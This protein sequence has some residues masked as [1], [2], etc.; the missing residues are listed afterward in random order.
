[1]DSKM[2]SFEQVK[3]ADSNVG[4]WSGYVKHLERIVYKSELP[5]FT[6]YIKDDANTQVQ[7]PKEVEIKTTLGNLLKDFKVDD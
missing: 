4:N 5:S 1:M 2:S 6:S 7:K 3:K